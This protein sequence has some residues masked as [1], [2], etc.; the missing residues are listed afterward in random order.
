MVKLKQKQTQTKRKLFAKHI[1]RI[2][3][4][5]KQS[6]RFIKRYPHRNVARV[7]HTMYDVIQ[8]ITSNMARLMVTQTIVNQPLQV[9]QRQKTRISPAYWTNIKPLSIPY[10]WPFMPN[11]N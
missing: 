10:K 7:I 4:Q 5:F 6:D 1:F 9:C 11:S 3:H 8:S 2:L